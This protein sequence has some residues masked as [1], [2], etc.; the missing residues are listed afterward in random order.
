[1]IAIVISPWYNISEVMRLEG[2]IYKIE[3]KATGKVYIGQTIQ[4]L[5]R[6]VRVHFWALEKGKH[7]NPYLQSSYDKY[8]EECFG[9][10]LL[11]T[12]D[13][14]DLD[15]AEVFWIAYYKAFK[16]V[17]NL[18]S[19]GG[20]NKELHESTRKK[21]SIITK[22][23]GWVKSKHPFAKKVIRLNDMKI[24][25]SAVE[26]AEEIGVTAKSIYQVCR[27]NNGANF[28]KD[29]KWY[30]FSYY[31][32]GKVYKA[33]EYDERKSKLPKKVKC[34]NTG[35]VFNS[36]R[37]AAQKMNLNQSKISLCCNGK[38]SYT[39]KSNDGVP[40]KWTFVE[41]PE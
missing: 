34:I 38:R 40:L 37:E 5:K 24:Y 27:G 18:E 32:E 33:K 2:I 13:A 35:E 3:N 19:G 8:G 41:A 10:S 22:S 28:G 23:H 26:A 9:S 20:R 30:Q 39:G 11:E 15:S 12:C 7:D 4:S 14:D 25:G 36:T 17:Y 6:R 1:L 29:G 16:G 21:M 31:E